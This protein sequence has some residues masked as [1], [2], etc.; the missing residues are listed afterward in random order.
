MARRHNTAPGQQNQPIAMKPE[1]DLFTTRPLQIA[2]EGSG[3]NELKPIS[4]VRETNPISFVVTG[5]EDDYLDPVFFVKLRLMVKSS[6]N[7]TLPADSAVALVNLFGQALFER[8][9]VKL[10][11]KSLTAEEYPYR[12]FIE[13]LLS[14]GPAAKQSQLCAEGFYKDAAGAVDVLD[15]KSNAG[16][17]S[18]RELC[19]QSKPVCLYVRLSTDLANQPRLLPNLVDVA[20]TLHQKSNAFRLMFP[21]DVET[22]KLAIDDV[23]LF[24]RTVQLAPSMASA[25]AETMRLQPLRYP[26]SHVV[27]KTFQIAENTT[28]VDRENLSRGQLPKAVVVGLVETDAYIGVGGK[29]PFNFKSKGVNQVCLYRDSEMVPSIP[30]QPNSGTGDCMREYLSLLQA[31]GQFGDDRGNDITYQDYAAGD[32]YSLFAFDLTPD[33]CGTGCHTAVTRSGNLSLKM[34]FN[35]KAVDQTCMIIVYMVYDSNLYI[36]NN[37]NVTLDFA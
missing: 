12:A 32:G 15:A 11:D 5:N 33:E 1:L 4:N 14:C 3:W 19:A 29:S 17:G 18:R 36:D 35:V 7:Q 10:Q 20:V 30:F 21:A 23:S 9:D 26:I 16:Y 37:R 27:V 2:I 25:I 22:P 13:R 6:T 8:V 31:A 34:N 24:Y 28:A